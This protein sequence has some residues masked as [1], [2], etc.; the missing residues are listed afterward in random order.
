MHDLLI[1]P[2]VFLIAA[3]LLVPLA[4][5]LGLGSVLGYLIAGAMIGPW[6]LALITRIDRISHVAE[7]GVVLML[8]L[9]GLELQPAK[10][11][12]MRALVL[13]GGALQMMAC[14]VALGRSDGCWVFPGPVRASPASPW[15]CP[16]PPSPCRT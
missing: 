10:L 4:Q 12:A 13:G 3:V 14:S 9:I 11:T 5:R 1:T 15:P 6:G 8:F 16:R 7:I 2:L